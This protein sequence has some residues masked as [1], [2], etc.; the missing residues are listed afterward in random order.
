MTPHVLHLLD[1]CSR[2]GAETL[3]LD[4]FRNYSDTDMFIYFCSFQGGELEKDLINTRVKSAKISRKYPVDLVAVLRLRRF[5]KSNRIDV[6]HTHFIVDTVHAYFAIIGLNV[7]IIHTHHGYDFYNSFK[8]KLSLF[9]LLPRIDAHI[10]VSKTLRKYYTE[11]YRCINNSF[12][13][14]NGVD[15]RKMVPTGKD[16]RQ[17]LG[18]DQSVILL[19][20]VGN[21][22]NTGRDQIT[23]CRALVRV[24]EDYPTVHFVFAGRNSAKNPIYYDECVE[25]CHLNNL[26]GNVHFVGSRNDVQDILNALDLYVY[27]SNHDTFGLTLVEAMMCDVPVI[28]NDLSPFLEI[29]DNGKYIDIYQTKN[30]TELSSK[31]LDKIS[32]LGHKVSS[33]EYARNNF[34]IQRH[35]NCLSSVYQKVLSSKPH[36]IVQD[37]DGFF[38]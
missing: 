2:G 10:F 38:T 1:T 14:Y 15:T 6:I 28:A 9:F 29:S 27:A 24:V 33:K 21:F 37:F 23:I 18:L 13:V 3:L 17:E 12:V 8:D 31:I 35:L 7:K 30:I 36:D 4:V 19:G 11:K 22:T 34:S 16:I 5:I 20:M 25:F 26:Q 32:S